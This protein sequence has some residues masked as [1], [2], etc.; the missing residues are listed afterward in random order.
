[1]KMGAAATPYSVPEE[2]DALPS[3]LLAIAV[4][5]ALFAFLWFGVRWQSET[6]VA[7]EAE[8]WSVAP[9]EA[10]PPPPPPAPEP[11][12]VKETPKPV[13]APP[14]EK[15]DIALEQEKKRK[16]QALRQEQL[17]KQEVAKRLDDEKKKEREQED[18]M[19]KLRDQDLKRMMA[20][21]DVGHGSAAKSQG[22][23]DPA[24][25]NL[26]G[27]KI[28]SNTNFPPPPG[29]NG[30]PAVEYEIYLLPDGSVRNVV[31]RKSSGLPSFDDAVRIAID[32]S[33]PFPADKSGKVQPAVL[34]T[35]KL[36]EEN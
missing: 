7:V 26:I 9:S 28:R 20:Q 6:P 8:V 36:I 16:E 27:A 11:V 3:L 32:R 22:P 31:L 4:H 24:Y 35:H 19:R 33:Q 30:N 15:P 14:V 25:A 18:R 2:P 12:V 23:G 1:M 34:V 29:V 10:A 21:A 17:Q 5:A 13:E